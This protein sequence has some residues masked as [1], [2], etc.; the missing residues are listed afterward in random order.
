MI[1]PYKKHD[2]PAITD[3]ANRAWQDIYDMFEETYGHELFRALTPD[4]QTCKGAQ[5]HHQAVH[6]PEWIYVCEDG[7]S[8]V[9]F[10][11]FSLDRD[12]GVGQIGNNAV[13][14]ARRGKGYAQ[15]MYQAVLERFREEGMA[16]ASVRTGLDKAH[17]AARKAYERAGFDIRHEDVCYYRKL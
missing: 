15:L 9:G 17:A 6:H 4:R 13:D 5:I 16:F 11:T 14:P 8:I 3:I 7:G 2:L 1:R 10:V 12:T